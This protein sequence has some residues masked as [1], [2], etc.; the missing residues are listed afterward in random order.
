MKKINIEKKVT[1][2]EYL[3]PN[4]QKVLVVISIFTFF[5]TF[6]IADSNF[7]FVLKISVF[8]LIIA[9]YSGLFFLLKFLQN[10]NTNLAEISFVEE[11]SAT[12]FSDEI[13]NNLLALEEANEFFGSSLKSDDMFRLVSSRI[14][15]MIPFAACALFVSDREKSTLKINCAT[16]EDAEK[17]KNLEIISSKGLA[18]KTFVS[19]KPQ[20]DDFLPDSEIFPAGTGQNLNSACTVPLFQK[21]EVFGVLELFGNSPK[22]FDEHALNILEAIGERV[23]PLFLNSLA[24]EKNLANALTDS[25]TKLPNERGFYL[26]FENQ[27]AESQRYRNERPLTILTIDIKKFG[28][29]NQRYGHSTGDNIL[30]FAADLLKEQLRQM[31]FL[32]RSASDEFLVILPT[33]AGDT[34]KEI[35]NRIEKAFRE[36]MFEI[37]AQEKFNL[38]LNFGSAT[39]WK[40]GETTNQ[41][42]TTAH[43]RKQQSKTDNAGNIIWFPKEYVN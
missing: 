10:K 21:G 35:T 29:L 33:A 23:A 43:L 38:Q 19:R 3:S 39:F 32:A 11:D 18:G 14:N 41:L 15:E 12:L 34:I 16:G 30:I 27:L 31:D 8:I 26:V 17:I 5:L 24:F 36:K 22:Q 20:I 6:L 40:D 4:S 28:E 42:L 37:S 13:E 25:L 9:A 2:Y 7:S 1:F